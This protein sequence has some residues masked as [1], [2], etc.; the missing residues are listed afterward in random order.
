[1]AAL[2]L[3]VRGHAGELAGPGDDNPQDTC[4]YDSK[5][6]FRHQVKDV[7]PSNYPGML[8]KIFLAGQSPWPEDKALSLVRSKP[9]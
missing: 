9:E 6:S 1:L 4:K 3:G 7:I 8:G 2:D 5:F